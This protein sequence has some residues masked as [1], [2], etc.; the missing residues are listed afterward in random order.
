LEDAGVRIVNPRL[1]GLR[2]GGVGGFT[3]EGDMMLG[4]SSLCLS[5]ANGRLGVD[6]ALPVNLFVLT[7]RFFRLR[8]FLG[9]AVR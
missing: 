1:L 2:F 5:T 8:P 4:S 9:G 3:N 7:A 6:A